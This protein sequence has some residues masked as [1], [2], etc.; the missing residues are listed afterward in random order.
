MIPFKHSLIPIQAVLKPNVSLGRSSI[1]QSFFIFFL[2]AFG[3]YTISIPMG[4][5]DKTLDAR[6]IQFPLR[7]NAK[8]KATLQKMADVMGEDSV[9]DTIR[10]CINPILKAIMSAEAGESKVSCALTMGKEMHH[11]VKRFQ[12]ATTSQET[13]DLEP[14]PEL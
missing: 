12:E 14:I 13:F 3:V 1:H 9:A 10:L 2:Q 5:I 6:T 4:G 7:V 8:E 11:I